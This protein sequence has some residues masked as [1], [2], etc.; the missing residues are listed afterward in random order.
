M[1]SRLK[2]KDLEEDRIRTASMYLET[3]YR[4]LL[5]FVETCGR[6]LP[7]LEMISSSSK[8]PPWSAKEVLYSSKQS[9]IWVAK[10]AL[11]LLV[12]VL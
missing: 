10:E 4:V 6:L 2:S 3:F 9:Q 8:A 11:L 5:L 1:W 12:G 7:P